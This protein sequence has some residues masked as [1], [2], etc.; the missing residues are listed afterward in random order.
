MFRHAHVGQE[1]NTESRGYVK[2]ASDRLAVFYVFTRDTA[3]LFSIKTS[4]TGGTRQ[5]SG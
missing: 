4:F 3:K 1:Q 5:R 2:S